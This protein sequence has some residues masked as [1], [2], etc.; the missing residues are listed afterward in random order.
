MAAP[1]LARSSSNS[2]APRQTKGVDRACSSP[3]RRAGILCAICRS[4]AASE[5]RR[6]PQECGNEIHVEFARRI[7]AF[8]TGLE[9]GYPADAFEQ[10]FFVVRTGAAHERAIDIEQHE[11][12]LI[13]SAV[14]AGV[15]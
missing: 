11:R 13:D 9:A 4:S 15:R 3:D 6:R 2:G 1:R 7:H 5:P 10:R 8:E 12:G 14:S